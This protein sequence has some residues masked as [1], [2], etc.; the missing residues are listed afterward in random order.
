MSD[1]VDPSFRVKACSGMGTV[2]AGDIVLSCRFD[3]HQR[4][5][6]TIVIDCEGDA[7]AGEFP[8]DAQL[9]GTTAAGQQVESRRAHIVSHT[10]S[11]GPLSPATRLRLKAGGLDVITPN[12]PW[13]T[14]RY[15]LTNFRKVL[16]NDEHHYT[17]PAGHP[18]W[19]RR[20]RFRL[21][22]FDVVVEH[23]S[24]TDA[25]LEELEITRGIAVT[26]EAIL[27][28]TP[29]KVAAAD[30]VMRRLCHLLTLGQ[31]ETVS[32]IYRDSVDAYGQIVAT[33]CGNAITKPYAAA[34]TL[35]ADE[36]LCAFVQATFGAWDDAEARWGIRNA[37]LAYSDAKIEIDYLESRAL[38]MAVVIEHLKR[39]Y[40]ERTGH[41]LTVPNEVFQAKV[42]D[43]RSRVMA[44]LKELYAGQPGEAL[45]HVLANLLG[46]LN[47]TPFKAALKGAAAE[48]RLP[49]DKRDLAALVLIRDRIVHAMQF[50]KDV[51]LEPTEQYSLLM[52]FAGRFMLA[53]LGY[54]G[55]YYDWSSRPPKLAKL[56]RLPDAHSS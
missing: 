45:G 43:L 34:H 32:W 36:D 10:P 31:G 39:V 56:E 54:D 5:D 33:F 52:E 53:A 8:R 37:I 23:H 1:R 51:E 30:E 9:I 21:G 41:E 6:G 25:V 15:G 14:L 20:I 3:A 12:R 16:G 48:L 27:T 18:G 28:A 46:G 44:V 11:M 22:E 50:S 13:T 19:R 35:I 2:T 7:H 26:A 38:K 17:T 49:L 47:R 42:T 24:D 55:R 29:A 40:L 4:S